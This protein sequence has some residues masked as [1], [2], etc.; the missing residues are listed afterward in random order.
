MN[1]QRYLTN[2]TKALDKSLER[3]ASGFRINKGSDDA[4][5]L[6]ISETLRAQIRGSSKALDNVQDG[7]AV[8]NMV[9]GGMSVIT[10]NLQRMRELAVQAAN[11]TLG[12]S[13]R[14]AIEEELDQLALDITRISDA[15]KFNGVNLMDG[16]MANFNVQVGA[17]NTAAQDVINLATA[18]A[19]NPFADID[20]T[21]LGVN[22]AAII[23]TANANALTSIGLIDTAI[24]TVTSRQATVGALTNRLE[25]AAQSLM[26]NIENISSAESRIRNVDVASESAALVKNQILQQASA[27]ILSQ[28]N[29][30]PS[31]ALNL[32][33]GG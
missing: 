13:Q 6:Q 15:M 11:D 32:I 23:V 24:S 16:S 19:S 27:T 1:A 28:A 26:V 10:Q 31:L 25:S 5:G 29:Q 33:R 18:G 3:L 22:D 4:A 17:N 14:T 20:A 21:A 9:D 7:V 8:L 12:T 30:T 2:N